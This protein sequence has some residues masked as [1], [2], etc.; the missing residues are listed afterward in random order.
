MPPR[1]KYAK[2]NE[3]VDKGCRV[4]LT[5]N[6]M[7]EATPRRIYFI[8]YYNL[9]VHQRQLPDGRITLTLYKKEETH[10]VTNTNE[11]P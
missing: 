4:T 9:K 7:R 3:L 5:Y 11:V 1:G 8:M 6:S 2:L 10:N